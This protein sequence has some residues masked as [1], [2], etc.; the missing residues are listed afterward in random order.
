L[1][2]RA[3]PCARHHRLPVGAGAFDVAGFHFQR[4]ALQQ[5]LRIIWHDAQRG[6]EIG[7][8]V[9]FAAERV[10]RRG[11]QHQEIGPAAVERK[12]GGQIAVGSAPVAQHGIGARTVGE[13]IGIARRQCQGGRKRTDGIAAATRQQPRIAGLIEEIGPLLRAANIFVAEAIQS[14]GSFGIAPQLHEYDGGTMTRR[15]IAAGIVPRDGGVQRH[16][17]IAFGER[18]AA[19]VP[20]GAGKRLVVQRGKIGGGVRGA[21]QH[22][23]S[24]NEESYAHQAP[25]AAF[26]PRQKSAMVGRTL[27]NA[28]VISSDKHVILQVI[29]RL[30]AGGAE[31]TT[32]DIAAALTREGFR[33][34][35]ASEGGRLEPQIATGGGQVVR[36]PLDTKA[37]QRMLANSLRLSRLIRERHVNLIHARSRAPAWS[38]LYAARANRVPLVTTYH[39]IYNA[40]HPLKRFYNSVMVRSDAVIA[41][42]QWTADHIVHEHGTARDRITVIHRGVDLEVFDPAGVEPARVEALRTQWGVDP[43]D[44]IVLLPGRLTRW[45]G[46]LVFIAALAQLERTGELKGVRAILLGDAQGREAYVAELRDAIARNGLDRIVRITPHTSDIP[47]AYLA[48]DIVVSASTDPEAFGRVAAEAGAMGIPVIATDHGGARETVLA[49][50]SGFLAT[51]GDVAALAKATRQLL[52]MTPEQWRDMGEAGRAHV[53]ANFSLDRMCADTLAIYRR[54]LLQR[55]PV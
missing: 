55:A 11:P 8:R 48:S 22:A 21:G 39:G 45:K 16:F 43:G 49:G 29:P 17:R 31:R 38:A 54:L 24:D 9:D 1:R 44:N 15:T 34:L 3:A 23:A 10:A 26:P 4:T 33:A 5:R 13:Q 46:Q 6:F 37:P 41:N 40:G 28:F 25:R 51:P 12:R 14:R 35:V 32:V 53:R 36:V 42:S 50:R 27:A 20:V 30:D 52:S 7:V 18:E 2:G 19:I 47:A